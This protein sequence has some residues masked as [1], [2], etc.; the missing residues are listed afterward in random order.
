MYQL[1]S[2]TGTSTMMLS[3][4][5]QSRRAVHL[6]ALANLFASEADDGKAINLRVDRSVSVNAAVPMRLRLIMTMITPTKPA[7]EP[8]MKTMSLAADADVLQ[9]AF[10]ILTAFQYPEDKE[11]AAVQLVL[12]AQGSDAEQ[13]ARVLRVLF[14]A[15]LKVR[16]AM[17]RELLC[18]VFFER[19]EK[20]DASKLGGSYKFVLSTEP[21]SEEQ[22]LAARVYAERSANRLAAR[23]ARPYSRPPATSPAAAATSSLAPTA[24]RAGAVALQGRQRGDQP[25]EPDKD[26]QNRGVV[27]LEEYGTEKSDK[28]ALAKAMEQLRASK[29]R[30]NVLVSRLEQSRRAVHLAALAN[31][32]AS[33]RD[34]DK[35]VEFVVHRTSYDNA[36]VPQRLRLI[37]TMITPT[38]PAVEPS[39]K[40]MSLKTDADERQASYEVLAAFQSPEDKE[41]AAVEVVLRPE[42]SDAVQL[43]KLL[44][45]LFFARLKV[46][47]ALQ[48]ELL[49]KV[50]FER[51][52]KE[53][54]SN[55]GRGF[56]FILRTEP[57]PEEDARIA[58]SYAARSAGRMAAS[59]ARRSEAK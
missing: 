31:L 36:A 1:R 59:E 30:A 43:A 16:D 14:L 7:V 3:G 5:E 11:A 39:M 4:L 48:R 29:S 35:V 8:S 45:V 6:A 42:V 15:R 49:C 50:L 20:E 33:Q 58:R 44:R 40:T 37:M 23:E 27:F 32:F 34:G 2:S 9:S 41:A 55:L 28:G 53:D 46:R 51:V 13:L 17:Q 12:R 54:T 25:D 47:D 26:P 19:V 22:A 10:E 52:D 21:L 38:K 57:L 18:Q 24:E 56:K